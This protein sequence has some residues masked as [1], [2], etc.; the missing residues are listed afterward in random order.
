MAVNVPSGG[1]VF[2]FLKSENQ[3]LSRD[4]PQHLMPPS[5]LTAQPLAT[6][7]N[8][9]AGGVAVAPQQAMAARSVNPQ[10]L[11]FPATRAVKPAG[12]GMSAGVAGSDVPF[13]AQQTLLPP[14][15]V[16]QR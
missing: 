4:G 1:D 11:K 6:E 10:V 2:H 8:S 9:P 16:S 13:L 15:G 5:I 14:G 12:V 7:R 3:R